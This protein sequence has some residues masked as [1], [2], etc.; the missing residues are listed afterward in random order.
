MISNKQQNTRVVISKLKCS[1]DLLSVLVRKS[2]MQMVPFV[3][4]FKGAFAL[5][6]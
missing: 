6:M 1:C 2:P 5:T 4:I 3:P